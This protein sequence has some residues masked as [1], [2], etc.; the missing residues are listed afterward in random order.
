MTPEPTVTPFRYRAR[1]WWGEILLADSDRTLLVEQSGREPELY[2]PLG[3]LQLAALDDEGPRANG[4]VDGPVRHW[5]I[6]VPGAAGA[7]PGGDPDGREVLR[8]F[9]EPVGVLRATAGAAT[10]DHHRTRVEVLDTVTGEPER[11]RTVKRFPV[12]GDA[13]DLVEVLD[14]RPTAEGCYAGAVRADC[15]RPVVEGSQML[16]QALVAA[17]RRAP[18]RRPV[19]AHMAFVRVADAREPLEVVLE[20]LRSGRTFTALGARVRQ[21]GALCAVG[22]LLLDVTA[23]DLVRHEVGAAPVAGPYECEPID[24]SVTGRDVRLADGVDPDDPDTLG[25]PVVDAW[26]RFR[27]VPEDPALHAGLLAQFTGHLSIT[28]AM[29]PHAG[30][31]QRDAHRSLSTAINAITL[32]L[33]GEV[34][35]DRWM[36]YHHRSTFAGAGMTHSECRVHREDGGLVASFAVEAMVRGFPEV[37]SP[38]DERTV[39]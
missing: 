3:D 24:M 15:R 37:G 29:R 39:L 19:S 28:A 10:F 17:S 2:F 34:R 4:G 21:G 1:A 5:S 14:V 30:I 31:G 22:T 35:A 32:S 8:A 12:W 11:D 6:R 38:A 36:R 18:G 27:S 16:A 25:P 26:V 7:G 13:A 9:V 20:E 33:H 23:P